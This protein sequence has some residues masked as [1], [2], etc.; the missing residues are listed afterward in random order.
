[1]LSDTDTHTYTLDFVQ[2][3][4]VPYFESIA[5][6]RSVGEVL[7]TLVPQQNP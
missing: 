5:V 6:T 4:Y 3:E 2:N 7:F 1:M